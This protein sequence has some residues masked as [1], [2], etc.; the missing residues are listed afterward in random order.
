MSGIMGRNIDRAR[1]MDGP[2]RT[3]D[4][5]GFDDAAR[6]HADAVRLIEGGKRVGD[7]VY[8]H[9]SLLAEQPPALLEFI[10]AVAGQ[11]GAPAAGFNVL[12]IALKEPEV[13]LLDYP[14]FF[15]DPFPSLRM[16]WLVN[17]KTGRV[18]PSDFA[19]R[20]N[21][22]ILHRKELL[23]A[24]D[25]P[26]RAPFARLTAE[27]EA[28][29]AFEHPSYLIGRRGYWQNALA[30]LGIRLEGHEVILDA[31]E[32]RGVPEP[33]QAPVVVA[34]HRTAIARSRLSTPMQ[35]LARW[36]FLDGTPTVF[37]YGCGRGDDVSILTAAGIE[38][39]G[40]DP[41]FAPGVPLEPA[42]VVNLG[43]VLNVIEQAAERAEALHRAYDLS[44]R[45]LAVAVMTGKGSGCGH[46]DGILT[47]RG[48][49]QRYFTQAELRGYIADELKREPVTVGPGV[50]FVF[51]SDEEEQ[52]FL[53]RRQRS[54]PMLSE[55]FEIPLVFVG[56][57]PRPSGYEQHQEL[58]DSFWTTVLELGRFPQANEF[59]RADELASTV[60]S[61]RKAFA[62][63]PFPGKEEDLARAAARRIDDLLVYLALNIFERRGSFQRMPAVIQRDIKGLFGSYKTAIE[64][65]RGEL[66]AAG[67]RERTATIAVEAA[68]RGSGVLAAHD[69]DYS[70]HASMLAQQPPPL[71]IILGCAE[72]LE[73]LPPNVDLVKV[74]GS[75]D[76]VSYLRFDRFGE[77]SLPVLTQ[78]TVINLRTQRV[79]EVPVDTPDGPR[80]LLGKASFMPADMP[81][82]AAQERF[83]EHLRQTGVLTQDGVGPGLR[84]FARR[85]NAAGMKV[86]GGATSPGTM[87]EK[88]PPPAV[89]P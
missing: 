69:G 77:R 84:A 41:H 21:P 82:R 83:D 11:A 16:S 80:V 71:R 49:F 27:L 9:T 89:S 38:A 75:G 40:W 36:G 18:A 6:R 64:R 3:A 43:F 52:A 57:S 15:E 8:L 68:A 5:H 46:A 44:R 67:N 78:R 7:A 26:A 1:P 34:R 53:A 25:H 32:A 58:L 35:A 2:T 39:R 48:T 73:P 23:L 79:A 12:R 47:S 81:G 4:P 24:K 42:E 37:D 51:R 88:L 61:T 14:A 17:L 29:G 54:S 62:S 60:G 50:V 45:V 74:H 76:R 66:F 10:A 70:F 65:A 56:P 86:L 28:C 63:L 22:P 13:A 19:T 87:D 55:R 20:E 85:L 59:A 33:G 72:R 31:T 30:S